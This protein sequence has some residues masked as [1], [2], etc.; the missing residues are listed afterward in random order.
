M[1]AGDIVAAINSSVGA[2]SDWDIQPS[3]GDEYKIVS[4]SSNQQ[5]TDVPDVDVK[6]FD[7]S[8]AP[9]FYDASA[10]SDTGYMSKPIYIN[11]SV[12]LRLTNGSG[13]SA[14][15]GYSGIQTKG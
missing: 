14:K 1:A 13:S 8:N 3:S 5:S 2:G 4:I 12:Y 11:N 6:Q 9:M 7:G 15:I 10:V